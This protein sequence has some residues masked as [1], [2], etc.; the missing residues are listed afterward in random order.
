MRSLMPETGWDYS[1]LNPC[2]HCGFCL[3]AC[4]TYLATGD[5]NDSPRGRIVL[6]RA[7]ERGELSPT[8]VS[9]RQH[10]D[11]CLGC[12]GCEPACPSGVAYGQGIEMARRQLAE[13]NGI[14]ASA[15]AALAVF[16]SR[17]LWRMAFAV[18]RT[19]RSS[20]L[21]RQLAGPGRIGMLMGMT[22]ATAPVRSRAPSATA[23][24]TTVTRGTVALFRG[25]VMDALFDHVH[26]ATIRVL[27]ANGFR[28]VEVRGQ[29]CCGAP[30][31]HSGAH[32][33]ARALARTNLE[34]FAGAADY[35]VVNSAGCG[36]LLKDYGHLLGTEAA[37]H[38]AERVKDVTELLAMAGPRPGAPLPIDVAYDAPCHLQH[39]QRVHADPLTVLR[40]IPG[41][42]LRLLPGYDRCCGG[43]G[44]YG[45]LHPE[46][47]ANILDDK[48][49]AIRDAD[50]RPG[51]VTTGN[52]GCIMQI[53]AGLRAAGLEIPVLHPV[54]LLDWSYAGGN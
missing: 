25:C 27:E 39:A 14:P 17:P 13:A 48:I 41:L 12:L 35:V 28:V 32:E 7:L 15:R 8:D 46:M 5:E 4:P 38:L 37:T 43:A 36:A 52:P 22:A 49:R 3:P 26:D 2:V 45:L 34:A 44:T 51:I 6:M 1:P 24:S 21:A 31:D 33:Q 42:R 10:L 11:A 54:Q 29:V 18:A 19:L 9:V 40:S 50:P 23:P 53:G 16:G 20:G 30:H 47:S